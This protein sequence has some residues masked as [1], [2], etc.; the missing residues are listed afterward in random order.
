MWFK[1][2]GTHKMIR[3]GVGVLLAQ[4]EREDLLARLM[5]EQ[6]AGSAGPAPPRGHTPTDQSI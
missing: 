2:T 6:S 1:F 4:V 5:L 3:V